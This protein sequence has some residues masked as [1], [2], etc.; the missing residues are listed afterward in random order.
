LGAHLQLS[1][2]SKRYGNVRAVADLS[3]SIERGECLA[4]LGPSGCGKT[5]ILRLIAGLERP[6]NGRL[7]LA[8]RDITKLSP[9]ARNIGLV[10][11]NYALFPHL[12][13]AENV[14]FGLAARNKP[15]NFINDRVAQ[16]L[17]LV[18]LGALGARRIHELSGG[19]QQRV[20]IA[21]AL[22]IEPEV[23]LLDE[24][25][26]NL[27]VA[28]RAQTGQQ[29]RALI[30][31]L[32]ITTIFVTH[33]Q[34]DAFALA[35]RIALL[36][37]GE[38]QQT[39]SAADIYFQPN[40]IFVARFIGRSNLLPAKKLGQVDG[41]AEYQI[42]DRLRLRAVAR[43]DSSTVTL[44]IRPEAILILDNEQETP[45]NDAAKLNAR[46]ISTRF[47]G[48]TIHYFLEVEGVQLEAIALTPIAEYQRCASR[49]G[50][51][52]IKIPPEAVTVFTK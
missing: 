30:E 43:G 41:M 20:A 25:L 37:E 22:A 16:A 9:E 38:L 28:L 24:P 36:N 35:D 13:V 51:C 8:E 52:R 44:Q 46:I 50:D 27:D 49:L 26:S 4:L 7:I 3:L 1:N 29:L 18:Q 17:E 14:A 48:S 11:Q 34:D 19:Q 6:D 40:N 2:L 10:F 42:G 15:R 33:D 32:H 5:T 45:D 39:G 23:L 21:R 12:S 31:R 47:A